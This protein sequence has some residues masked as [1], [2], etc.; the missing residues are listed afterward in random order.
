VLL[1]VV[2]DTGNVS[3]DF[4]TVGQTN[5]GDL[6]QS[7]VRLLRSRSTNCGADTSL[8]GRRQIGLGALQG[9]Q[10]TLQSGRS[11]LVSHLVATLVDQLIKSRHGFPPFLTCSPLLGLDLYFNTISLNL[12][13]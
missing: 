4:H 7:G 2:T 8:L 11:G 13:C 5:T 3:G 9:V 10:A 12:F 1:Q 6:T